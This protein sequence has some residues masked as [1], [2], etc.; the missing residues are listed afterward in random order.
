MHQECVI[1]PP[2]KKRK[3]FQVS[4]TVPSVLLYHIPSTPR[5]FPLGNCFNFD[6]KYIYLSFL[7]QFQ[8]LFSKQICQLYALALVCLSANQALV[9]LLKHGKQIPFGWNSAGGCTPGPYLKFA[10]GK[11]PYGFSWDHSRA[12]PKYPP[13]DTHAMEAGFQHQLFR[14]PHLFQMWCT[15]GWCKQNRRMLPRDSSVG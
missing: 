5:E 12:S 1:P 4:C 7:F 11:F 3:T 14:C 8:S 2:K 6:P 9:C 15:I 13:Q 10:V